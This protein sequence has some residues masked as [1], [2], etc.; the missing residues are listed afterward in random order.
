MKLISYET[1]EGPALGVL[2]G[3]KCFVDLRAAHEAAVVAGASGEIAPLLWRDMNAF[4]A[5]G[6]EALTA[7]AQAVEFAQGEGKFQHSVA[8]VHLLAPVPFPRKLFCLAGN[9]AEHILESR[10][11]LEEADKAT[12]RVF[13]KPPSTTVRGPY[14]PIVITPVAQAIDWEA[15]LAVV[16]GRRGKYLKA[17]NALDYIAGYTCFNDVSERQLKI[18]E[19]PETREWD[20]FFDWLNGKWLDSFAPMGPCLVTKD[21]IPDPHSLDIRLYLNGEQMQAGNTGQMIFHLGDI[22]EYISAIVTLEPG[23]VI[24]TGTPSG[25]GSARGIFL[26]P[27][28]VVRTE[29]EGIGAME[30]PVVAGE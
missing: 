8:E 7:A 4:L 22:L 28:D 1:G 6:E 29:I 23:D 12:P 13:M 5:A 11:R 30:N 17:E 24:S 26:Q 18:K 3:E 15:E 9:Y 21:E 2:V 27:G 19:R 20:Q 25:V 10:Q 16:I 14:D